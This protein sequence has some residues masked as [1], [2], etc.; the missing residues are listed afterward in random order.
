MSR[1]INNSVPRCRHSHP[2]AAIHLP[3][4]R[5]VAGEALL[6]IVKVEGANSNKPEWVHRAAASSSTLLGG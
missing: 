4:A 2:P 5:V 6:N 1:P 3:L